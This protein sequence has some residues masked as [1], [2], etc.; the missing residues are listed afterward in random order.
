M[1]IANY[2]L[3]KVEQDRILYIYEEIKCSFPNATLKNCGDTLG[4]VEEEGHFLCCFALSHGVVRV[5]FNNQTWLN[6]ND[7]VSIQK[8]MNLT[9]K[10]FNASNITMEEIC[11]NKTI[12]L[13]RSFQ[14]TFTYEYIHM[15]EDF[16]LYD[17]AKTLITEDKFSINFDACSNR[18]KNALYRNHIYKIEDLIALSP[19]QVI[20][21]PSLGCKSFRELCNFLLDPKSKEIEIKN[22]HRSSLSSQTNLMKSK[23][24][25][26]KLQ[27][28]QYIKENRRSIFI[29]INDRMIDFIDEIEI[30]QALYVELINH[31]YESAS[32]KLKSRESAI[33]LSRLGVNEDAKT[34]QE[35]GT[36]HS[37]T[38]ER[39]RQI[40]NKSVRK[41][42]HTHTNTDVLL[43]L[44]YRKIQIVSKIYELSAGKFLSFL[45]LQEASY[46][47]I[48]FICKQYLHSDLDISK[49]RFEIY[50]DIYLKKLED[51]KQEKAL[52]YNDRVYQLIS[53]PGKKRNI[54]N[55]DFSRLNIERFVN[56][57][58]D[59]LKHYIFNNKRYQCESYLEQHILH[60]FLVNNT[61]KDI[62]TQS[63][64]IPFKDGFYYPDFQCLTHDNCFVIIEIKPVFNMCEYVNIEKFE[65]L[66]MYCEK[67][68]FGYLIVD[69]RGNSFESINEENEAFSECVLSE[70]NKRGCLYYGTYKQIFSQTNASV[71]NMLTIIKKYKLKFLTPFS[72]T[73]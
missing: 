48:D 17:Q 53:F 44:E 25:E 32:V 47:L 20:K 7:F 41:I 18:L 19:L 54:T 61:F 31:I 4:I 67:Y 72:L 65:A 37:I 12:E 42:S 52:I 57:E 70:I 69:E 66:K 35:I 49:F 38:R 50:N 16:A 34:F 5:K 30:Y 23:E 29:D 51:I 71:K 6:L 56:S 45:F 14:G 43:D 33:I 2:E 9:I 39:V 21:I 22:K 59:E 64:K 28:I 62:K 11:D 46:S 24:E 63:L 13:H 73:K 55:D 68:G 36:I 15:L 8:H 60:K 10:S 27:K 1:K 58:E 26:E 3:T 40:F